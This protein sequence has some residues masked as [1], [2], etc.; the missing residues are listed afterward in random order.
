MTGSRLLFAGYGG[1]GRYRRSLH[2]GLLAQD[3]LIVFDEAHL[4]PSF[5]QTLEAIDRQMKR[6]NLI[7]PFHVMLL[8]ATLPPAAQAGGQPAFGLTP[9]DLQDDRVTKRM[10]AKKSLRFLPSTEDEDQADIIAKAAQKLAQS[11]KSV[12]VLLST[13]K[14]VNQVADKLRVQLPKEQ[15]DRVLPVTGEMRGKERDDLIAHPVLAAF[16][17]NRQRLANALPAF[18]VATSCVEVGFN[19]DADHALCDLVPLERMIQRF[20]RV[21]RFGEVCSDINVVLSGSMRSFLKNSAPVVR[22]TFV[23]LSRLRKIGPNQ[24]DVSPRALMNLQRHVVNQAFTPAPPSPPLDESRVDDWAMTSLSAEG[25]QR[26]Q[27]SYWLR[28]VVADDTMTTGFCWRSDLAYASTPDDAKAMARAIPASPREVAQVNTLA[29]GKDLVR[30]IAEHHGQAWAVILSSAGTWQA[31]R[32]TELA[33]DEDLVSQL[34]FATVY[35]P[36][37]AGGFLFGLPNTTPAAFKLPVPD[38]VDERLW[39][40]VVLRDSEDGILAAKLHANGDFEEAGV[41]GTDSEAVKALCQQWQAKRVHISGG[42]PT[43][44]HDVEFKPGLLR[45]AY[46]Q[47]RTTEALTGSETDLASLASTPV[48]L[49]SHLEISRLVATRLTQALGLDAVLADAIIKACERHDTGKDRKWWQDAIGNTDREPLAKSGEFIFNNELN[50]GYRHEFGSLLEAAADPSLDNHPRRELIFHLIAAHHGWGR[51]SFEP[52]AY[53]RSQPKPVCEQ[54]NHEAALRYARLQH[55][56]GWWQL[57]YLEALVKCVDAIAS[58]NPNW[59]NL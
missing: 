21:N 29:R 14:M 40:R 34:A 24:R 20:G 22:A 7:Q 48:P 50:A 42:D 59:S 6:T 38:A 35:L 17:P 45:V 27:V 2:A 18:L 30:K 51:P 15:R 52:T 23:A 44:M 3:A 54:V 39:I 26:P 46:L 25:Y 1:L 57:A 49:L 4:T 41:F 5:A 33:E 31:C 56:Y 12:A 47:P 43:G 58:A 8:S 9:A 13:V 53:D 55:E 28:G 32:L 10:D 19:F 16:A 36:S 11:G 37:T